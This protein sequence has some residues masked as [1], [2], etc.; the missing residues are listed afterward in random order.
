MS[1]HTIPKQFKYHAV[2]VNLM[3]QLVRYGVIRYL[4]RYYSESFFLFFLSFFLSVCLSVCL[5]VFLSFLPPSLPPFLPSFLPSCQSV[6]LGPHLQYM[7]VPRLGVESELQ[8]PSYAIAKAM[9]DL[10]QVCHLH[11]S[12]RQ[13]YVL[14]PLTGARDRTHI[15]MDTSQAHNL[16]SCNRN[17]LRVL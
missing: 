4:V 15:L 14:N 11:C 10:T 6:F 8:L 2:M 13:C 16:L 17:S 7:E 12:S 3:C 5:S 1:L 9:L